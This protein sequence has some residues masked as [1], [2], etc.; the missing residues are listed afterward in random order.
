MNKQAKRPLIKT[1]SGG[2][3]GGGTEI[4]KDGERVIE[5]FKELNQSFQRFNEGETKKL[6]F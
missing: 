5:L 3:G 4:T 1:I 2:A 6:N